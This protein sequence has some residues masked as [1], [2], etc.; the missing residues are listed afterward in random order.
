MFRRMGLALATMLICGGAAF[1]DQIEGNWKTQSGETAAIADCGGG[2]CITLKTGRHKG[3]LIGKMSADGDG[4]YSGSITDPQSE[5]TYSGSAS[6]TGATMKMRG[7]VLGGLICKSQT[8][9]KK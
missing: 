9:K 6:V 7:C 5:K 1:A 2:F 3:K 4:E 8:W